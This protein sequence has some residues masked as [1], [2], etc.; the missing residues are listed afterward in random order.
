LVLVDFL[1]KP[2]GQAFEFFGP[3]LTDEKYFGKGTAIGIGIRKNSNKLKSTFNEAIKA[4][5]TNGVYKT[6]NDK[7][8]SFDIYHGK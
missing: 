1:Q 2:Q 4:I 6:I 8:F 5:R 7:Y 3:K